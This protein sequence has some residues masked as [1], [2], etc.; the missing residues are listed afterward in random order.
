[1]EDVLNCFQRHENGSWTCVSPT[2]INHP[3]GRIQVTVGSTFQ[4]GTIFM[5]VDLASWLDEQASRQN[6]RRQG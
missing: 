6:W 1:M 2:T 5:G 4:P 3:H